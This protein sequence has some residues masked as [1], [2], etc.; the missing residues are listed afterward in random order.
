MTVETR[1]SRRRAEDLRSIEDRL[2]N[3]G[4]ARATNSS[5]HAT[6]NGKRSLQRVVNVA[7]GVGWEHQRRE[8]VLQRTHFRDRDLRVATLQMSKRHIEFSEVV[9][10]AAPVKRLIA[11]DSHHR[12]GGHRS[13]HRMP[14]DAARHLACF[15]ERFHCATRI[16]QI[17]TEAITASIDVTRRARSVSQS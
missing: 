16:T 4:V 3:G 7:I 13:L 1:E 10:L 5:D 9:L 2:P 8:V 14:T 15:V 17:P 6:D 12:L 11:D